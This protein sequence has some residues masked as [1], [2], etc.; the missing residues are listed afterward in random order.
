MSDETPVSGGSG[1]P[2]GRQEFTGDLGL[3]GGKDTSD[4]APTEGPEG[5]P[6][7]P[8]DS[9]AGTQSRDAVSTTPEQY[10]P[11]QP[12]QAPTPQKFS[13]YGREWDTPDAAEQHFRSMEGR[14]RAQGQNLS[15]LQIEVAEK[16]DLVR[17][18][19]DWYQAE[20]AKRE[21]PSE[22][23]QKGEE[24]LNAVD[25]N[26]VEA[27]SKQKGIINGLKAAVVQLGDHLEKKYSSVG[28]KL[29]QTR[30]ELERPAREAQELYQADQ[31]A[32]GWL[33]KAAMYVDESGQ[34]IYPELHDEASTFSEPLARVTVATWGKLV[35]AYPQFA[36]S[37]D[38]LDLAV[39]KAK[40]ILA[41]QSQAR[42]TGD[43]ARNGAQN[44]AR[45]AQGRFLKQS[46][47]AVRDEA[48]GGTGANP[49]DMTREPATSVS[50]AEQRRAIREA[51][52]PSKA[53]SFFGVA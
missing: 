19:N 22:P 20:Q 39:S 47:N 38:G 12:S 53:A 27:I 6:E 44:V 29:V 15:Q 3:S 35:R 28:E 4:I 13:F 5:V 41:R 46:E 2:S 36:M 10:V 33:Y 50:E 21:Q 40:E 8:A 7:T 24:Y 43:Q 51:G 49:A 52:R 17:R 23:E 18:W 1:A 42:A 26:T 16:A 48:E 31:E 37:R 14:V 30:E 32:K 9:P 11:G 34:P 45:D 25:W